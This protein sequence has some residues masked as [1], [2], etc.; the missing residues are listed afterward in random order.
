MEVLPIHPCVPSPCVLLVSVWS[1]LPR[2]DFRA[3]PDLLS[4]LPSILHIR[5][6]PISVVDPARCSCLVSGM[7]VGPSAVL[8]LG[9]LAFVFVYGDV[10]SFRIRSSWVNM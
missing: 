8:E 4:S 7:V 1:V 10:G 9:C 2:I 5:V 6:F 3:L